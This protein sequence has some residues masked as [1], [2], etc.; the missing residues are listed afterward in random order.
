VGADYMLIVKDAYVLVG[1]YTLSQ[2][3]PLRGHPGL[4]IL[5]GM[6]KDFGTR[7]YMTKLCLWI[8]KE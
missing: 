1:E 5:S 8:P 4:V 2:S 6:K 3:R 7:C